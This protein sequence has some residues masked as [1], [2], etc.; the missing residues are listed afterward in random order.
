MIHTI[1]AYTGDGVM[2]AV[3]TRLRPNGREG[4]LVQS[5]AAYKTYFAGH[6]EAWEGIAYMKSRAVAGNVERA[7]EFLHELQEVDW[8]RYGQSMRSRKELAEMRAR[9]ER[10][11]GAAQSAEGRHGR[12]STIST[13]R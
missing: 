9:L 4:D 12:L 2:F 1:S 3:D 7:T 6:A 10:E 13:S 8:R 5:E 11:Q